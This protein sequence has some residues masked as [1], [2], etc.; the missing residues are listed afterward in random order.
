MSSQ[1][2]PISD[3]QSTA[4]VGNGAWSTTISTSPALR[5]FIARLTESTRRAFERRRPWYELIDYTAFSKPESLSDATSRIR[6]NYNY[7]RVNYITLLTAVLAF[8]LFSHPFSLLT[9]VSLIGAWMFLYLFRASD[10]PVVIAGRTFSDR[11]IL[12]ILSLF[13][14]FVVFLTSVGSLLMSA[15]LIGSGII[16]VH[17]AFRDPEDLFL[18]EQENAGVGLFSSFGS[19]ATSAAVAD[20]MARV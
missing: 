8:S 9:I 16:A 13:T 18:D 2:L 14:I 5:A 12:G 7:F 17:G 11:E 10:Q 19:S 15:T 3:P 20:V 1:S 4:T 6:K